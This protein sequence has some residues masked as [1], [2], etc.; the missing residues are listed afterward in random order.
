MQPNP[1]TPEAKARAFIDH[2]RQFH[3]GFLPTECANPLTATLENDFRRDRITGV[4]TLQRPDRS[5]T[6]VMRKVFASD[7]FSALADAFTRVLSA[8]KGRIVFSGCGATGRLS[9][10][11]ETIWRDFF[12]R[13]ASELS[14]D[15]RALADRVESI[16]TGGDFAL[17]KAVEA[18]EDYAQGGARQVAERGLGPEDVLVGITEGGETSSVLGTLQAASERGAACFLLFNN[19]AQLLR[20]RLDR[21]R[22]AIDN[23]AITVLDLFCGPMA[24]AGSTRMQATTSEQLVASIALETA[25]CRVLPRFA[26]EAGGDG[27]D[28]YDALLDS[29]ESDAVRKGLADAIAF[30][31]ELYRNG[32]KLTYLADE[33][34][35]DLFT[36]TTER[37]PTFMLPPFRSTEERHLAPSW[38]FVKNPLVPTTTCWTRLMHRAPRCL[39][40]TAEDYRALGMPDVARKPPRITSEDLLRYPIGNE[41]A[42]ERSDDLPF[43]AAV[44]FTVGTPAPAFLAAARAFPG[45]FTKRAEIHIGTE[46]PASSEGES[47]TVSLPIEWKASPLE[48]WR[49]LAVKL[50]LNTISTGTM[51]RLGRVAGNWMSWVNVSN[52]KLIDRGV[53]LLSDLGKTSYEDACIRLFRAMDFVDRHDWGQKDR[54]SPV[55]V[56]LRELQR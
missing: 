40:W 16:M 53:R 24:L 47:A 36:D 48:L 14:A 55:Q 43:S 10:L 25:L 34:M 42:P 17:I 45:A 20:E 28:L 8:P 26:P 56:A 5:I 4:A 35:L 23:P 33:C 39:E 2:E 19:P 44:V 38:A 37:S 21:C 1:D 52:K 49:H 32:G 46:P 9:I 27:S 6:P 13:R 15:E 12:I 41:P 3:L 7:E 29:L 51:V 31:E 22:R 54:P 30:E 11:L 18:F 50:S